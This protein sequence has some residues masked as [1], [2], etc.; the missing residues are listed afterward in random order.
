MLF[1]SHGIHWLDAHG[2][3]CRGETSQSTE[4]ANED[5]REYRRPEVHLEVG[6][7]DAIL[8]VCHFQHL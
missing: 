3:P 2:S 8:R 4:D 1:V 5:G 7:E 6:G